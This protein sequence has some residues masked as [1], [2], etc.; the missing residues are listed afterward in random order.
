MDEVDVVIVEWVRGLGD[1]LQPKAEE[2]SGRV[3]NAAFEHVFCVGAG[4]EGSI[5][6]VGAGGLKD[7]GGEAHFGNDET[8]RE[9]GNLLGFLLALL[10]FYE[11]TSPLHIRNLAPP[12]YTS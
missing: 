5:G 10:E 6:I 1:L 8:N 11:I 4:G 12:L 7:D 3:L 2:G 9:G